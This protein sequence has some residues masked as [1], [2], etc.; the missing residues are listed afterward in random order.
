MSSFA[1]LSY[2]TLWVFNKAAESDTVPPLPLLGFLWLY[3]SSCH[4][5]W[6]QFVLCL[7]ALWSLNEIAH[8]CIMH[9]A[10]AYTEVVV[11]EM[12][13]SAHNPCYLLTLS[14]SFFLLLFLLV[15]LHTQI[16][17]HLSFI[18]ILI[19][20]LQSSIIWFSQ[21]SRIPSLTSAWTSEELR[22]QWLFFSMSKTHLGSSYHSENKSPLSWMKNRSPFCLYSTLSFTST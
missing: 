6:L 15:L 19:L 16:S 12:L 1:S 8:T 3:L 14:V 13:S 4:I 10:N 9:N 5:L 7:L 18:P 21:T 11:H 22:W 17:I 20:Q 2:F